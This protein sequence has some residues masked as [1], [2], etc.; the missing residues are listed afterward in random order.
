MFEG[1]FAD[2]C[3]NKFRWFQ[4]WSSEVSRV[5]KHGSEEPHQHFSAHVFAKS[6]SNI[7]PNASEVISEVLETFENTP[8]FRQKIQ[9][10]ALCVCVCNSCLFSMLTDLCVLYPSPKY[11][12]WWPQQVLK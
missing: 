10:T 2:T 9:H 3:V 8:L 11:I 7:S 4:G 1:D 6:P 12:C 5:R